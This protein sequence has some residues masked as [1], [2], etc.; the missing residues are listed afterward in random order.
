[1]RSSG[2]DSERLRSA[3]ESVFYFALYRI[4]SELLTLRLVDH[5]GAVVCASCSA[6]LY[7]CVV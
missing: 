6:I 4:S 7:I 5:Y 2:G 3:V 1:M